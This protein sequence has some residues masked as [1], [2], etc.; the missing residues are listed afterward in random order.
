MILSKNFYIAICDDDSAYIQYA[1][2]LFLNKKAKEEHLIFTE[3][4][5]GE[6]LL[7]DLEKSENCDLLFLDMQLT[8]MDG[9]ATARAFR[10][11]F[12]DA[13]LIFC[14]GVYLP[15]TESFETLPFRY[16]LKSYSKERME[17]ELE[18]IFDKMRSI[19]PSPIL[20]GKRN[21]Q[22][23]R[24]H[25]SVIEYIEIAKRGSVI[26]TFE[27]GKSVSYTSGLKVS[28]HYEKLCDFGFVYAHNSYIVHLNSIS[29]ITSTEIQLL[30]GEKLSISRSHTKNFRQKFAAYVSAKY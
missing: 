3:Y 16:L 14:S 12:P 23:C 27:D 10:N 2:N 4:L 30:S 5:S 24:I 11:K 20:F 18:Q 26:H 6:E 22:S 21:R 7:A 8:G 13:L 28:E 9:N 19:K 25:A 1:K 15:S 29:V 17:Y